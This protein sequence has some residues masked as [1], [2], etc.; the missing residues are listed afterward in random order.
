[1]PNDY[2]PRRAACIIPRGFPPPTGPSVLSIDTHTPY[3]VG[4]PGEAG[5]Y[6]LR[7]VGATGEKGS[8]S[9]TA[10]ATIGAQGN[11]GR[12]RSYG[13]TTGLCQRPPSPTPQE[14]RND[15]GIER[16]VSKSR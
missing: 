3:V 12:S 8:W 10:S 2:I 6:M 16:D 5:R 4:Y 1:M 13:T 14:I 11:R 7:W 9:E 15:I